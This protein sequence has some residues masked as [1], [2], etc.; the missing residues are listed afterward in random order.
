MSSFRAAA[1]LTPQRRLLLSSFLRFGVVGTTGFVVDT[2][3]LYAVKGVIGLYAGAL[4]SYVV[5]ATWTWWLNRT[6]TFRGL[7]QG[8][9][10][11]QWLHF[12]ATNLAG[13]ACNRTV[14]YVL[15]TMSPLANAQPIIALAAGAIA[16][17]F[18]NFVLS[19]RLVF[20]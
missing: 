14:Y 6:W 15:V 13:F 16:G 11:R 18:A 10:W 19:R 9:W 2:V 20:R 17:L 7:G 4:V 12:M 1:L 8:P 5:A 3:A